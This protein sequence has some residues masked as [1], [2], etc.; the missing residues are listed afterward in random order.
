MLPA[1]LLPVFG[2]VMPSRTTSENEPAVPVQ[3]PVS[4]AVVTPA[5]A[6]VPWNAA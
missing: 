1:M 4:F 2:I 3:I 6:N 5:P